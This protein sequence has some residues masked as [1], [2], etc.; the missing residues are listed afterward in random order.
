MTKPLTVEDA[1]NF[2]ILQHDPKVRCI[3]S[4]QKVGAKTFWTKSSGSQTVLT[5]EA[6]INLSC[7]VRVIKKEDE[8]L[9]QA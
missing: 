3:G 2:A 4:F 1:P 5:K 6:H 8:K 7:T 9:P